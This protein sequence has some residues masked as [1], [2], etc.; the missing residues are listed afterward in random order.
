MLLFVLH[1]NDR[2]GSW[3]ICNSKINH[4]C[5]C[6]THHWVG[7]TLQRCAH[8]RTGS[9]RKSLLVIQPT[10]RT[11]LAWYAI[12]SIIF[13]ATYSF[14]VSPQGPKA[15]KNRLHM[16]TWKSKASDLKFQVMIP[17]YRPF[18][19]IGHTQEELNT[20]EE[21]INWSQNKPSQVS[22]ATPF[23]KNVKLTKS[24]RKNTFYTRDLWRPTF[25]FWIWRIVS[26]M[27]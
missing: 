1:S 20:S 6:H 25:T 9:G 2:V 8:L 11:A 27:T 3:P 5:S 22:H 14:N 12:T 16:G 17:Q 26:H 21:Q 4:V 15:Q 13:C 7:M 24:T 23:K 10:F 19:K 18:L